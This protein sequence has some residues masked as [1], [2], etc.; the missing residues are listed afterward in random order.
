MSIDHIITHL[1]LLKMALDTQIEKG[2]DSDALKNSRQAL[3]E[4]QLLL[5]SMKIREEMEKTR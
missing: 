5:A 1:G 3:V 4:A 2:D